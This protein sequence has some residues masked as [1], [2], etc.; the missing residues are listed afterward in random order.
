MR[1]ILFALRSKHPTLGARLR[2]R[3]A[4]DHPKRTKPGAGNSPSD[5]P[6]PGPTPWPTVVERLGNSP[7]PSTSCDL[8]EK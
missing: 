1:P 4:S 2:R 3:S 6:T 7:S 5:T 8:G